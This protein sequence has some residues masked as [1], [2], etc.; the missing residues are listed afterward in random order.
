VL[1]QVA[2]VAL[3]EQLWN[4]V[5][6]RTK[7]PC[8]AEEYFSLRGV[9]GALCETRRQYFRMHM[10]ETGILLRG[11]ERHA[12]YTKDVSPKGVGFLGPV[13]IFPGERII[14]VLH[15]A[16]KLD[17]ELRRCRRVAEQCYECGTVF[18]D[19]VIPPTVYKRLIQSQRRRH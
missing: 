6:S 2:D 14:M 10:R 9:A 11:A 4:S 18:V 13:Q 8:D 7:L 19:G 15:D 17:L 16:S 5:A 3:S 1:D 12:V